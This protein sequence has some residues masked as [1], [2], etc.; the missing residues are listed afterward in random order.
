MITSTT[1]IPVKS[2]GDSLSAT[3]FNELNQ[4]FNRSI[5][6]LEILYASGG[7]GGSGGITLGET[8][9]TAYRG[10][11]GALAYTHSLST[12]NPHAVTKTQIGLGNVDNTTDLAKPISTATLTALNAKADSTDLSS[13][14]TTSNLSS[15]T[16]NTSNPHLV[17]KTQ[18][19]L[20]N[21]DNTSDVS[22]PV[23]T[24]TLTALGF[25]ADVTTLNNYATTTSLSDHLNNV[26]NPHTTTKSQVGLSNV[27]NTSDANKPVSSSTQTAL[28]LKQNTA[29]LGNDVVEALKTKIVTSTPNVLN[30]AGSYALNFSTAQVFTLTLTGDTTLSN[31]A[32][33]VIN[34][35]YTLDINQDNAGLH[36]LSWGSYFKF[37]NGDK[38][39]LSLDPNAFD[40]FSIYVKSATELCVTYAQNFR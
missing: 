36:T 39:I 19:G 28:N 22:K 40:I 7:S 23:S 17:T 37:P 21:V 35:F 14:A 20:G 26:S 16:G 29:T 30:V 8:S 12:S 10:D 15:H 32:S 6:D 38:P 27:D 24:A 1:N 33:P 11:R 18:I 34:A 31:P 9:I 5:A 4:K 3:E 2:T 25:K 13:Y